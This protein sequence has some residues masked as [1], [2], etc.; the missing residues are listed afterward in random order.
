[1]A[2]TT[3]RIS[4]TIFAIIASTFLQ[5]LFS[6]QRRHGPVGLCRDILP[7]TNPSSSI[8]KQHHDDLVEVDGIQSVKGYL[9]QN[10]R[11]RPCQAFSESYY[12]ARSKFR[13]A[14]NRL[15]NVKHHSLQ[16]IPDGD[17]TIDIAV[18]PGDGDGLVIHTSGC[19]GVEGYAGSAIQVAFL[20]HLASI[21]DNDVAAAKNEAHQKGAQHMPTII[22]VHALNP[23]G[24]A[25]F[26][27]TNENNVDLNRN[28][29][30]DDEWPEVLGRDPNLVGYDDFDVTMFN[31]RH[32]PSLYG[33]YVTV[34]VKAIT[35]IARYGFVNMKRSLVAAQYHNPRGIFYGGT[36]LQASHVLLRDFL[37]KEGYSENTSGIVT[38]IDVHTGLGPTG[39]DTLLAHGVPDDT[40]NGTADSGD[41]TSKGGVDRWFP[42]APRPVQY[43]FGQVGKSNDKAAKLASGANSDVT[44]GYDLS[45]GIMN[46][47]YA[48]LFTASPSA[49]PLVVTQE[50]GTR[51]GIFVARG[52]ILENMAFHYVPEEQP[53]WSAFSR[54]VFYVRT[55]E[56]RRS[57]L[58]RGL[59]VLRQAIERSLSS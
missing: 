17:Y 13:Y 7:D 50:F 4:T 53:R 47:Y 26:R 35:A 1:M 34:F 12:E 5:Y 49:R 30:S 24:M 43:H 25:H 40:P 37:M 21:S 15:D 22:L 44:A 55:D 48:K 31:P 11:A 19:H 46:D 54:D 2:P 39:V 10:I 57:I 51:S 38:W 6:L 8:N 23:Y 20:H 14:A 52:M 45:V 28:A 41:D 16:V 32:S 27:R 9:A 36:K 33:A 29:L 42:D 3:I 59:T 18:I 56:W 58:T